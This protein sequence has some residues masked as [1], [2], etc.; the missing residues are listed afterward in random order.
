MVTK[1]YRPAQFS[2]QYHLCLARRLAMSFNRNVVILA[3][4]LIPVPVF[5]QQN[6]ASHAAAAPHASAPSLSG[7]RGRSTPVVQHPQQ[8]AVAHQNFG[9]H[10]R[11]NLRG[12]YYGYGTPYALPYDSESDQLPGH[13]ELDQ[14]QAPDP[15]GNHA[16]PTIFEHNGMPQSAAALSAP[17]QGTDSAVDAASETLLIFRDGHQQAIGNYALTPTKLFVLGENSEKI[18]LTDLDLDATI[19]ANADRGVNFKRPSQS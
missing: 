19:K 11:R 13:G 14:A 6:Q 2:P 12:T 18:E 7:A 15:A 9:Q 4:A 10:P 3:A 1:L 5:A 8:P 16:G 17:S